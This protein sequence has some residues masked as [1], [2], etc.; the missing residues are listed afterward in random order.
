[1]FCVLFLTTSVIAC[2]QASHNKQNNIEEHNYLES[3]KQGM[4]KQELINQIGM[5]DSIIDLGRV[6]DENQYTQHIITFFYGTNQAVTLINDTIS[7][8]DYNI[9]ETE[10]RIRARIDSAGRTDY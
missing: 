9:K 7:G 3:V 6:T 10:A 8:L 2:K 4:T 1:M 5:P